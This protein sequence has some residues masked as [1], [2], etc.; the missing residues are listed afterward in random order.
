MLPDVSFTL[1][2]QFPVQ[3]HE[4]GVHQHLAPSLYMLFRMVD[5]AD[6]VLE[7]QASNFG[8]NTVVKL[9]NEHGSLLQSL[10]NTT[11]VRNVRKV[12]AQI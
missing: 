12:H 1:V 5:G 3:C 8:R 2:I 11:S 10:L 9:L 4:I 7:I 6:G